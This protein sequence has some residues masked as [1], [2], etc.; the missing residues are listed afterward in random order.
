MLKTNLAY[1]EYTF[2]G[3]KVLALY[4]LAH[5]RFSLLEDDAAV[6]IGMML[7]RKSREDIV[8]D[9][10]RE[11]GD[12]VA[13]ELNVFIDTWTR[14]F[15][16]GAQVNS[17]E[18]DAFSCPPLGKGESAEDKFFH[19]C[20][21]EHILGI[22]NCELTYL[23]SQ[24]CVHCYNPHHRSDG[25][26]STEIWCDIIDQAAN[27]GV[28][29]LVLTGGECTCHPGFWQI[30]EHAR[31]RNMAVT[32]QSNGLYFDN[33]EKMQR[34]AALFPRDYEVSIYGATAET[35]E[36]ITTIKGSWARTLKSLELAK[37]YGIPI[38]IKSPVMTLNYHEMEQ[39]GELAKRLGAGQQMDICI[40]CQNDGK[41]NPL[42][43]RVE[44]PEI[45]L[46]LIANKNLPLYSGMEKLSRQKEIK[47]P[48]DG[49][50]C[51]AG[52]NS[53][54]VSPTG[55]VNACATLIDPLGNLK[56]DKLEAIWNGDKLKA[57]R[58][59][60]L[61]DKTKCASCDLNGYCSMCPGLSLSESGNIFSPG[62]FD[63][64]CA[65]IR[66]NILSKKI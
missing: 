1:N 24:R 55:D 51:G 31:F 27:L 34:L 33:E 64:L 29:R 14:N 53:L 4:E 63:C 15:E 48:L 60:K 52:S 10:V 56:H 26:L 44:D 2:K 57:F 22:L 5:N 43:L 62:K 28:L 38:A 6:V 47:R 36:K 39:I 61:Q 17:L 46:S 21:D 49:S 65:E 18:R 11:R 30:L 58:D 7:S 59:I 32:V 66:Q 45:L 20:G 8:A 41:K 50:L 35:H 19:Q 9:F 54:C 12:S 40:T 25:N 13:D 16:S 37:K 42:K 3:R 23:C